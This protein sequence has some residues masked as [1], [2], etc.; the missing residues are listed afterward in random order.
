[1]TALLFP[2]MF[3]VRVVEA[4][5]FAR[6]VGHL[7]RREPVVQPTTT[8]EWAVVVVALILVTVFAVPALAQG[9]NPECVQIFG[10]L[11]KIAYGIEQ[12]IP[13]FCGHP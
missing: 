10:P 4:K 6:N 5:N 2:V 12:F 3:F 7:E 13:T 11:N 8:S 9:V 1:M